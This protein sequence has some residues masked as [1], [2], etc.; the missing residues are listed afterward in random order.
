[1]TSQRECT[2]PTAHEWEEDVG[3]PDEQVVDDLRA[4]QAQVGWN[5]EA[6]IEWARHLSYAKAQLW[7]DG[8]I[9]HACSY[10]HLSPLGK[11][12]SDEQPE[13]SGQAENCHQ[14]I[15][16]TDARPLPT[17]VCAAT[18]IESTEWFATRLFSGGPLTH[19]AARR[20]FEIQVW[21]A[22]WPLPVGEQSIRRFARTHWIKRSRLPAPLLPNNPNAA[23]GLWIERHLPDGVVRLLGL[24]CRKVLVR[25]DGVELLYFTEPTIIKIP[26]PIT[27]SSHVPRHD[28]LH[29]TAI[30][31][32]QWYRKTLLDKPL[33]HLGRPAGPPLDFD[34]CEAKAYRQVLDEMRRSRRSVNYTSVAV[35]L[36]EL[37]NHQIGRS[38]LQYWIRRGWLPPLPTQEP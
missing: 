15:L 21:R 10:R 22:T 18:M 2:G 34:E 17:H 13:T 27:Y 11:G 4:F 14:A 7:V 20:N 19:P 36:G 38:K 25:E 1:M 35:A 24:L 6:E 23:V 26:A 16:T 28:P 8:P 32:D 37:L 9:D 30:Q 12:T 3:L 29:N 33:V 5:V 31:L